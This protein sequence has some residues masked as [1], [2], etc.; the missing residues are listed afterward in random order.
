E[1]YDDKSG[2]SH[3][4]SRWEPVLPALLPLAAGRQGGG[5]LCPGRDAG[6]AAAL[7]VLAS[8]VASSD[9]SGSGTAGPEGAGRSASGSIALR[10]P[11]GACCGCSRP[12]C[13]RPASRA[14]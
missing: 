12:R 1:E 2:L 8:V 6:E 4:E 9:R 13:T 14:P 11:C 10:R 3:T 5:G 7:A